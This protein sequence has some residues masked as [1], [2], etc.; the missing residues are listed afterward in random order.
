MSAKQILE[1]K[2][3][4]FNRFFFQITVI[5]AGIILICFSTPGLAAT[6]SISNGDFSNNLNDWAVSGTNLPITSTARV[7]SAPLS[8]QVGST[9]STVG[10][11][12][13]QQTFTLPGDCTSATVTAYCSFA[14]NNPGL[15][16]IDFENQGIQIL[17]GLGAAVSPEVLLNTNTAI[18]EWWPISFNLVPYSLSHTDRTLQIRFRVIDDGGGDPETMWVDDVSVDCITATPTNTPTITPTRSPTLTITSTLTITETPTISPTVTV[19]PT[20]TPIPTKT[21]TIT[22]TPVVFPTGKS[23]VY[24]NPATGDT[25]NFFYSLE[26][27]ANILIDVYN[28]MG[29]RVAHL[30]DRNR[31]AAINQVTTWNIKGVAGGVYFYRLTLEAPDGRRTTLESKKIVIV[32]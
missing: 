19:T 7:R 3:L 13:L 11:S 23:A 32:R 21:I 27:P 18:G 12:N 29:F 10:D 9:E 8:A 15:T 6:A 28:L 14:S 17:D 5:A 2:S 30:E 31:P 26:A 24:P 22:F 25:L 20:I 4:L 16:W 1:R